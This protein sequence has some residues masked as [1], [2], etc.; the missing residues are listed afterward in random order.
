MSALEMD[1]PILP[2]GAKNAADM[3]RMAAE[4]RKRLMQGPAV[5]PAPR[6]TLAIPEVA[7]R[8]MQIVA[9][10]A[11]KHERDWLAV[12]S[13]DHEED[14]APPIV[15]TSPPTPL[16]VIQT[17]CKHFRIGRERLVSRK[18]DEDICYARRIAM[19]LA[20]KLC[21]DDAS[22]LGRAFNRDRSTVFQMAKALK[23]T[24]DNDP[25][26]IPEVEKLWEVLEGPIP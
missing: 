2:A 10:R 23:I 11:L 14:V 20:V 12:A 17:V 19:Y 16:E 9:R 8:D 24:L 25:E 3:I 18:R 7:K 15:R 26:L 5:R 4:R 6:Q 22:A 13:P 1:I 21:A